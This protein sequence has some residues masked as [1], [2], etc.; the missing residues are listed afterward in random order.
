MNRLEAEWLITV[1]PCKGAFVRAF[2]IQDLEEIYELRA[3]TV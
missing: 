3:I 1:F 2:T